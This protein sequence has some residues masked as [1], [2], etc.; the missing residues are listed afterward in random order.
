MMRTLVKSARRVLPNREHTIDEKKESRPATD[1]GDMGLEPVRGS[2]AGA[3]PTHHEDEPI[4]IPRPSESTV[5][6]TP[7]PQ[8]WEWPYRYYTPKLAQRYAIKY[9]H[10]K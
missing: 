9:S 8:K 7:G 3:E 6:A 5:S 1:P 4:N 10:S 2:E